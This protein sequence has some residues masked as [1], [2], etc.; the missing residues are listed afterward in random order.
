MSELLKPGMDPAFTQVSEQLAQLDDLKI[1]KLKLQNEN[2]Y[3]RRGNR[4]RPHLK[5]VLRA[6]A[7]ALML[8]VWHLA[9]YRT[10]RKASRAHGMTERTWFAG[11][12]LLLAA[13]VWDK[14]GFTTDDADTI[15]TRIKATVE[16]A[17]RD[18]SVIGY[19]IPKVKRPK[20]FV[21]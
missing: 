9:G 21:E 10:G 12:A 18:P 7:A 16:R 11:R 3:L 4:V 14:D 8:A 20:A 5:L 19:R 2:H 1:A 13:R 15:Q 6:E 17:K